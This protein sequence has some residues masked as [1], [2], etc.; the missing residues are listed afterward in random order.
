MKKTILCFYAVFAWTLFLLPSPAQQTPTQNISTQQ[1]LPNQTVYYPSS[2]LPKVGCYSGQSPIHPSGKPAHLI[3][4]PAKGGKRLTRT[5]IWQD[6]RSHPINHS[7]SSAMTLHESDPGY[8]DS[9]SYHLVQPQQP[10]IVEAQGWTRDQK[11]RIHLT[12]K[13]STFQGYGA[14]C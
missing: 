3:P 10:V 2:A 11:G 1:K 6:L 14:K 8:G 7:S 9:R 13:S 5:A 4:S 12:S